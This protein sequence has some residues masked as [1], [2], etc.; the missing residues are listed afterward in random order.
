[1][2][3]DTTLSSVGIF[4]DIP[5]EPA[6]D[7]R[8]G[9]QELLSD[10]AIDGANGEAKNVGS[11][12]KDYQELTG[13]VRQKGLLTKQPRYYAANFLITLS[14][15]GFGIA[16]LAVTDALWVHLLDAVLLSTVFARLAFLGHDVGHRQ[17][18]RS[19]RRNDMTGLGIALLLGME[20]TWWVEKHNRHH[21]NPNQMGMDP[22]MD[23]P[24][25]AFS[26]DDARSKRGLYRLIVRYQVWLFYPMLS[27]EGMLGL[28][29]A[30][31][32]YLLHN[33]GKYPGIEQLLFAGHFVI[34]FGLLFYLLPTWHAVG[35][36]VIHQL[37]FGLHM[38]AVFAPNHKG[39]PVL[40]K[41]SEIDYLT[42]QV[43]TARNIKASPFIDFMYGGLNYQ[44]EHH[45]FPN[46]PRNRLGEAQEIVRAFCLERSLPY[47]ETGVFKSHREILGYFN[48]TSAPL[49]KSSSRSS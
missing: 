4:Q 40:E 11:W 49:R 23:I 27:M 34:Y 29:L 15:M 48:E 46:M 1:M 45:L 22:D 14:M 35:F 7:S 44:I 42:Q 19:A 18:F 47:H 30:G 39:M 17:I 32:I 12:S 16:I 28:R 36:I 3:E 10:G 37:L 20:R 24:V 21:S 13:L 43:V 6:A 41:G 33:K 2:T 8:Q 38:G 5:E 9:I 31:F 25:L 26:Q